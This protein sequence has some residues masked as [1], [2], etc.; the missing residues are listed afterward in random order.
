M[1]QHSVTLPG[2][3]R[4]PDPKA[5]GAVGRAVTFGRRPT[6]GERI[7]VDDD[8]QSAIEVQKT[9]LLARAA[10]TSFEGV[11]RNP[12]P[13]SVLLQLEETDR[14]VLLEG[15][16]EYLHG[17]LGD[18]VAEQLDGNTFKLALGVEV[19]GEKYDLIEFTPEPQPLSGYDE[20]KLE[21]Q[22]GTG[23]RKDVALISREAVALAQSEGDLR[24]D[25]PV[26]V[27]LLE[28]LDA[29]D[30]IELLR[31]FAD[32]RASFRARR[33]TAAGTGQ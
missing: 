23:V 18:G 7:K 16:L 5:G 19:D 30:G 26:E 9:L 31:Y 25:R 24:L 12:V 15:Y 11:R 17:S 29:Y 1:K 28:R 21:R 33:R 27:D 14:E 32:R 2:G 13:L 3:Y 10:I 6:L 8:A 22:F 4:S 20:V